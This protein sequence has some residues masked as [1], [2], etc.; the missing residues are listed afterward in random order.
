MR[1]V[2][3][4]A[5]HAQQLPLPENGWVNRISQAWFALAAA[6]TAGGSFLAAF[7]LGVRE[8]LIEGAGGALL[9]GACL[10]FLAGLRRIV[11]P[12]TTNSVSAPH[13]KG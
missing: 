1:Q 9:G 10:A 2:R 6:F 3:S 8:A 7:G 5:D 13:R 11:E 12:G 4:I